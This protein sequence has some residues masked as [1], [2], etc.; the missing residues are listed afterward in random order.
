MA[1]VVCPYCFARYPDRRLEFRCLQS[2]RGTV[3]GTPCPPETDD[4]LTA[5]RGL[6]GPVKA[7]PV[8]PG[9]RSGHRE[10]CPTCG[11]PSTKRVC[12]ECHNDLPSGYAGIDGR[13]IALVGP[14]TSGKSI[15]TTVLVHELRGRI[16]EA[17]EIS[18]NAMDDRTEQRYAHQCAELFD[19]GAL[20]N[21]TRSAATDLVYPLLFRFTTPRSRLR[22]A[23]LPN[24]RLPGSR[25][26]GSR[27]AANALAFFDTAG[28][29]LTSEESTSRHVSYLA[30]ADGIVLLVDPLQFGVVR[31]KVGHALPDLPPPGTPPARIAGIIGQLIRDRRGLAAG[32]RIGTPLAV[33]LTK[34]DVLWPL[35][36]GGSRLRS[37]ARHDGRLDLADLAQVNDEVKALLQEWDQG[38]LRRQ[39]EADFTTSA[40]FGLSALGGRPDGPN[41]APASGV[42]PLRTDD[43]I[44]W[45]LAEFGLVPVEKAR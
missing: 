28:E 14:K 43:P 12:P 40:F 22:G 38:A 11:V 23:R 9:R 45:L 39:V 24:A 20:P 10:P 36:D 13:I 17:F 18:L 37:P 26:F 44:L 1:N 29:D 35:L 7:G 27:V 34:T 8:F 33:A 19:K 5:F 16:G 42:R 21:I 15:Y 41:S 6:A 25:L 31:D 2:P 4:R 3:S 32:R 30:E